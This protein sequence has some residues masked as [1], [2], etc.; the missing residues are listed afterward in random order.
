MNQA[1]D[2][3]RLHEQQLDQADPLR[4]WREAFW[5][6]HHGDGEQSYFC[7]NSLGLQPRAV[8]GFMDEELAQWR[9]LGVESHFKGE[10]PWMTYLDALKEPMAR[11][12]GAKPD[13]VVTMNTL[14]VNLHL[15]M[16][17][18]FRPQGERNRIVIER[19][20][21]PSDRYAVESQLRFH[22]LNPDECLVELGANSGERLI[23]EAELEDYLQREGERV[24]LVLWPGV[25]YATGQSFDLQ[26][27]T[28]AAHKAGAMA[29]FDLAHSVGNTS[30]D[31]HGAG[32][33]FAAWCTYKYLNAGPGAV[34]GA[35]VHE[36]HH[37]RNDLPRLHGWWGCDPAT[38]FLMGPD[39]MPAPGVDAWLM[40]NS[41]IFSTAPLRVSLDIFEAA[42]FDRLRDKSLA[43]TGY[44]EQ[45]IRAE[46]D[47]VLEI[48][49]PSD[50]ARRGCQLSLAVRDGRDAGRALFDSLIAAGVVGDWREPD[51]IRVAPVPL[52][53]RFEDC[54]T[55]VEQVKLWRK[56]G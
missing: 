23:D 19:Q 33:D 2:T 17:S 12:V 20:P 22:G 55:F 13:E 32:A 3:T 50:P 24:A 46:L 43:L 26:R 15:M 29:G 35:F 52:Y 14:T 27:I 49:T 36:R 41:P 34:G 7:G 48:I 54:W 28:R 6:P 25:Q 44:L 10:R 11:L 18:F 39:F 4:A 37:D 51:I 9:D 42:G 53:N 5:I 47:D 8:A 45:L 21:F 31:L 1:L 16:V 30:L 40:S 56:R 38:R